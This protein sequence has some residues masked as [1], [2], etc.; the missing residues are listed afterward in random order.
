[1]TRPIRL[2]IQARIDTPIV[3]GWLR[4]AILLPVSALAGL[5][6][7]QL[8]GIFAH[9]WHTFAVMIFW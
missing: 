6:E 4:P 7:E 9:D 3:V 8:L 1:L 2:L 5:S